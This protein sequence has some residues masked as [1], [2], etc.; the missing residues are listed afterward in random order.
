MRSHSGTRRM[1][2]PSRS[3]ID[4]QLIYER[5]S[6]VRTIAVSRSSG[7]AMARWWTG[8]H[9]GQCVG[10]WSVCPG[11]LASSGRSAGDAS[12]VVGRALDEAVRRAVLACEGLQA[13]V[14]RGIPSWP[15]LFLRVGLWW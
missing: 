5:V 6:S 14:R 2:Q 10:W 1:V 7:L 13:F 12:A 11:A 4:S 15:R 8:C 3:R 9:V